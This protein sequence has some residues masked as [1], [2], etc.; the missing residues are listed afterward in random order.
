MIMNMS[1]LA[2]P[3]LVEPTNVRTLH[4]YPSHPQYVR[5][6]TLLLPWEQNCHVQSPTSNGTVMGII[7]YIPITT[8]NLFVSG[9]A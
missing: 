7:L 5:R 4:T 3:L 1:P 8:N 6:G 9:L 2:R